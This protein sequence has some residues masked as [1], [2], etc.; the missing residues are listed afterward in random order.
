MEAPGTVM[1]DMPPR[2]LVP[3]TAAPPADLAPIKTGGSPPSDIVPTKS[4]APTA[5][6]NGGM[7][8]LGQVIPDI[9]HDIHSGLDTLSDSMKRVGSGGDAMSILAGP[10]TSLA[11]PEA[12]LGAAEVVGAPVT[13]TARALIGDPLRN[14]VKQRSGT[15]ISSLGEQ[16]RRAAAKLPAFSQDPKAAERAANAIANAAEGAALMFGPSA[17]GDLTTSIK[18]APSAVR[19]L[20]E[21]GVMLTP[22]Q[23]NTKFLKRLEEGAKSVPLLG[24]FIRKAE[25][26]TLDSFNVATVRQQV[27]PLGDLGDV[28]NGREAMIKAHDIADQKYAS[29]RANVPALTRDGQF[30]TDIAVLKLDMDEM[31]QTVKQRLEAVLKNRVTSKWDTQFDTMTGDK[32]KSTESELSNIVRQYRYASDDK[33][34]KFAVGVERIRDALRDNLGRQY[35]KLADDLKELNGVYARLADID[36][37]QA[38]RKGAEGRFTPGDL[39]T[40]IRRQ[41]RSPRHTAFNEGTRPMQQWAEDANKVI[42]DKVGDSGT[43]ERLQV[44]ELTDTM[45]RESIPGMVAAATVSLPYTGVGQK[46]VN[47]LARRTPSEIARDLGVASSRSAPV[48]NAAEES[49]R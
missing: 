45:K 8:A 22:G 16:E 37:A 26:R 38:V 13:G 33:D 1:A 10:A 11:G 36:Y 21:G 49:Q 28:K 25:E 15:A 14:Y 3:I 5:A 42:G 23:L 9:W 32:F 7:H 43:A 46:A 47:A 18:S 17:I 39:L 44:R 40:G 19:R 4:A 29:F 20:L 2:D 24:S 30:D 34:R 35:P 48:A 41:D 12:L 31:D 27:A 6:S